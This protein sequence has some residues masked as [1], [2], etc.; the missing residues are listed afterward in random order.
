M[1]DCVPGVGMLLMRKQEYDFRNH[2]RLKFF[3]GVIKSSQGGAG[4]F[5][6]AADF[7]DIAVPCQRFRRQMRWRK[8][9]AGM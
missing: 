5:G 9:A 4:F 8:R 3:Q 1:G 6:K 7:G 2:T